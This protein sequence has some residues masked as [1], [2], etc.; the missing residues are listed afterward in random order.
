[1]FEDFIGSD[2]MH[3]DTLWWRSGLTQVA[4]PTTEVHSMH[5]MGTHTSGAQAAVHPLAVW[6]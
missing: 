5:S 1:M 4:Q 3:T 6:L 2:P